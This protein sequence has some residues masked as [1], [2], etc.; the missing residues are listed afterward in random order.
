[1]QLLWRWGHSHHLAAALLAGSWG[2]RG[3]DSDSSSL[4]SSRLPMFAR[5]RPCS[6]PQQKSCAWK[7]ALIS[8][9]GRGLAG[10]RGDPR[11]P[12]GMLRAGVPRRDA[13][14]THRVAFCRVCKPVLSQL[15]NSAPA[16]PA[17]S[18]AV[19]AD[20]GIPQRPGFMALL[21][22]AG[23]GPGAQLGLSRA[24]QI[25]DSSVPG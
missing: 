25:E 23:G 1:M 14:A 10:A 21:V 22:G 19:A 17:A 18:T 3:K 7:R 11:D 8:T 5:R 16:C 20:P 4:P 6:L 2:R 15:P 12:R 24:L 9:L 13:A